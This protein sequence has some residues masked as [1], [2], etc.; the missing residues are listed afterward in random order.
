MMYIEHFVLLAGAYNLGFFYFLF[1]KLL[2]VYKDE[3]QIFYIRTET[4]NSNESHP[5]IYFRIGVSPHDK[6]KFIHIQN[7]LNMKK[8][9]QI[10]TISDVTLNDKLREWNEENEAFRVQLRIAYA[11]DNS[12][13]DEE[14]ENLLSLSDFEEAGA[15]VGK[16]YTCLINFDSLLT[17]KHT[18]KEQDRALAKLVE[19]FK[20]KKA[21][22]ST[23][24]FTISE[25]TDGKEKA[26][27]DGT[28]TYS[29]LAN[30]YLGS[31]EDE[32]NEFNKLKN[33]MLDMVDNDFDF[34]QVDAD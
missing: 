22:F 24:D 31:V 26:I 8:I 18:E 9:N 28:H 4:R 7:S 23:F 2:C 1:S 29:S 30:T 14:D 10:A 3:K 21:R 6:N 13:D 32:E 12:K 33:R 16:T 34:G 20:G 11:A 25:L 5:G 27:N 17:D 15:S 19:K